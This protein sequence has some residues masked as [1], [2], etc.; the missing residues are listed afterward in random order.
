SERYY[1][2]LHHVISF[3]SNQSGDILENLVKVCPACHRALTPDRAN[4]DYQ[5]K[6]IKNILLNSKE[7]NKYVE[8]F[9]QDP[10]D[11]NMKIE[12][13]FANLK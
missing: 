6:L 5:K 3:G 2:E 11:Y 1:F 7:A 4:E 10:N 12:Y 9:I 8:N 13:V